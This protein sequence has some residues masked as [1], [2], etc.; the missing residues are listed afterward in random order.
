MR[1]LGRRHGLLGAA[2]VAL[3]P[4]RASAADPVD[5]AILGG[6]LAGL[7]AARALIADRKKVLVFEARDRIGGRAVTDRSLGFAVDLGA[8]W[9]TPGPLAKELA[10]EGGGKLLPGPEV[11]A[12]V[13]SGRPLNAD[14]M[15]DYAKAA[16]RM[17]ALVKDLHG[18]MPDADPAAYIRPLTPNEVLAFGR[19]LNKPPFAQAQ[20]LE[21]G[22]GAAVARFGAKVPVKLGTRV[23]RID[24]T[25][26]SG[27]EYIEVVT[28]AGTFLARVVIV[29]L[30]ASVLGGGHMGFSPP[31]PQ[32]KRDALA[33]TTMA[34]NLRIAVA[35]QPGM[36]KAPADAHVAGVTRAGLPFDIF[37]RPQNRDAAIIVLESA[38]ARQIE[39]AGAN[40]AGAFALTT[41]AEIY[42]ND[43]RAAFKG[44]VASRWGR[45]PF[46]LGA[47]CVPP[48]GA[49][50]ILAAPHDKRVFFAGEAMADPAGT[51]EAAYAS[52]LRSAAEAKAAL[53]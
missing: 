5:V 2:G 39:E 27:G 37:V 28:T 33:A 4:A 32:K 24:S 34:S 53:R 26:S 50:A 43:L 42:G 14:Q 44:S 11:G 35:F 49:P 20:P 48:H 16:E 6:G 21:G 3:L 9:L 31:L 23:L 38:A 18:R 45:D 25:G 22:I 19:I 36:P 7:T 41:L 46:A 47:W 17:A 51:L 8:S 13:M 12:I 1:P 15:A 30:P 10:R 52:G 40:A 29:A